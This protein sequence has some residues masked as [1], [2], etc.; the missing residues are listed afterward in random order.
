MNSQDLLQLGRGAVPRPAR[1]WKTRI[2][3][4]AV[5]VIAVTWLLGYAARGALSRR[6]DVWV[7]PVVAKAGADEPGAGRVNGV[8][9]VAP[10]WIEPSPYPVIVPA[11]VEGVVRE[12]L[13]LEGDRVEEGQVVARLEKRDAG[14]A[15]RR[16]EAELAERRAAIDR[17]RADAGA[18]EFR[19]DELRD[20]IH[21]KRE[22]VSIGG[23][24]AGEFARLELRLRGAEQEIASAKATL[25]MAESAAATGEVMREEAALAVE[26]TEVRS[27]VSGTV[28]SRHVEPGTRIQMSKG[29]DSMNTT[30][31][32]V[33]NPEKVQVRVDV[34]LADIGKVTRG[35]A[36]QITTEALPDVT[37]EGRVILI[38]H[39]ASVQRNTVS[40]KVAV[41]APSPVLKPEML[42]KVRIFSGGTGTRSSDA[43]STTSLRVLAPETAV[44]DRVGDTGSVWHVD[45]RSVATRRRV[46]TRGAAAAGHILVTGLH[47][48]DR[49]VVDP[50]A[51]LQDGARVR[52]LG[53][54][55]VGGL[56]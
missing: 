14:L 32:R 28:L 8:S 43:P 49:L 1:R 46:E 50:P 29:S 13:V 45:A 19:A 52:V 11:L 23:V 42:A 47:P 51:S 30:V 31:L 2:L 26:R 38:G 55:A 22:L 17:A 7:V 16:I 34:P 18:A 4:P 6:I 20:E 40:V 37:L 21:R 27:P 33:Y 24:G 53:E 12:V 35:A 36:A 25:A 48:G 10:G 9:V 54:R 39:E 5:L 56:P 15:L 41:E 44:F 3:L